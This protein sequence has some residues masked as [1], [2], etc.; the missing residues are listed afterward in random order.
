[1]IVLRS[2]VF[3]VHFYVATAGLLLGSLVLRLIPDRFVP[4]WPHKM[5]HS[6]ARLV[7]WGMRVFCDMR[8]E[9]TGREHLPAGQV[10][11]ASMH[12]SAF[13]TIVWLLLLPE[14]AY[15]LKIELMRI[16]LFGA[17]CRL[18]EMIV[19]DRAGGAATIRSL[20][21]GA[22]R[23][24]KQGRSIVIFPEGTRVAPGVRAPLHPGIAALASHTGLPVVPVLTDSGFFWGRR[25][26]T[27]YPGVIRIAI[28]PTL[29]ARM[30]RPALMQA[31]ADQ[32]A[33]GL[34]PRPV[35]NSVGSAKAG[36]T[37]GGNSER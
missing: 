35:D 30:P 31:L 21:R 32:F 29:P 36:F 5:A 23:V 22:D 12:Q 37:R 33:A 15:V 28:Q 13:D 25:T 16:P 18:T 14:P 20:L 8:Y 19:V 1:M 6:W 27:R 4:G 2:A 9:V 17:L 7:V 24:L 26:F 3:L 10:L 11:I 34:P